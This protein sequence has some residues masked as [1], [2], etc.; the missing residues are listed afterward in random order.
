MKGGSAVLNDEKNHLMDSYFRKIA[1]PYRLGKPVLTGS[2]MPGF[3]DSMAVDCPFVFF[4]QGKFHMLYVGFDGIGYQTALAV[5]TDLIHWEHKGVVL[6]RDQGGEWDRVGAAGTWILKESNCIDE[7]PVL[8]KVN[9]KYWMVYHSYPNEGYEEGAA[10]M[11]L[12][13]TGDENLLGWHRLPQPIYSWK[14]GEE[15]EKGG[16]YKACLIEDSGSYYLFYNAKNSTYGSWTEQIGV[17]RSSDL[18][19]WERYEGNPILKVRQ[20]SWESRF[21]SDPCVLHDGEYW[22]MLYFGFDGH[23]AQDGLAISKDLYHWQKAEKP[24]L[25]HGESGELDEIHAHKASVVWHKDVLYHFYC[26]CRKYREG[27]P[28]KN[29]G[30][31]FRCITVATSKPISV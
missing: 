7:T 8:K 15:W 17:A 4:H 16:L 25:R 14:D 30:D 5:S 26:A 1:T 18:I 31:E 11:G 29:L 6:K 23:H 13:W 27:D 12:A 2:G 10:Q 20:N 19:H 21:C 22:I 24:I 28:T 9:N 3:F